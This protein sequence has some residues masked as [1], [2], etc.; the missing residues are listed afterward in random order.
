MTNDTIEIT[1]NDI[2]TELIE[3]PSGPFSGTAKKTTDKNNIN[4]ILTAGTTI[5]QLGLHLHGMMHSSKKPTELQD[6]SEA[7]GQAIKSNGELQE[8]VVLVAHYMFNSGFSDASELLYQQVMKCSPNTASSLGANA[9][10][11]AH[12]L[13]DLKNGGK[14]NFDKNLSRIVR[15]DPSLSEGSY[16]PLIL[17]NTV[18]EAGSKFSEDPLVAFLQGS[19]AAK[20]LSGREDTHPARLNE[21][22]DLFTRAISLDSEGKQDLVKRAKVVRTHYAQDGSDEISRAIDVGLEAHSN[23]FYDKAM[24]EGSRTKRIDLLKQSLAVYSR[25]IGSLVELGKTYEAKDKLAEA[26]RTWK[27][28]Y[29]VNPDQEIT[30][31]KGIGNVKEALYKASNKLGHVLEKKKDFAGALETYKTALSTNHDN[32]NAL[33]WVERTQAK[34]K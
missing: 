16:E 9:G 20:L 27:K 22:S 15:K 17:G 4:S 29:E 34:L 33:R 6:E 21:V 28:V 23:T 25:N 3:R 2:W 1:T 7:V 31:L 19:Y 24:A 12:A 14:E 11:M 18:A 30:D 32:K 13:K 5:H 26:Q 10:L 8:R